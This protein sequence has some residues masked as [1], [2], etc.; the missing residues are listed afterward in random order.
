VVRHIKGFGVK[1][2]WERDQFEDPSVDGEYNIESDLKE[3]G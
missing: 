3:I 1:T 2:L